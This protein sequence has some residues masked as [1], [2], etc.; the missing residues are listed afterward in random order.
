MEQ[1]RGR[2][3]GEIH[4]VHRN[5]CPFDPKLVFLLFFASRLQ[6]V[7]PLPASEATRYLQKDSRKWLSLKQKRRKN[8]KAV[9]YYIPL[10]V[11]VTCKRCFLNCSDA[12]THT[13]KAQNIK[14]LQKLLHTKIHT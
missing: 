7:G 3:P 1:L 11:V 5:G 9:I 10:E 12:H 13:K 2:R 6:N 4:Q 8:P 14:L